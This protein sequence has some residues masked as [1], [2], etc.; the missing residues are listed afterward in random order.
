METYVQVIP[1]RDTLIQTVQSVATVVSV[2]Q[3]KFCK[4]QIY[5]ITW[6]DIT[7]QCKNNL[8]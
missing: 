2:G 5:V 6:N 3:L 1:S 7:M 8:N 4:K